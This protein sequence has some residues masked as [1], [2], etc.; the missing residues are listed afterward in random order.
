MN[1]S[2]DGVLIW[3]CADKKY[4]C[5]NGKHITIADRWIHVVLSKIDCQSNYKICIDGQYLSKLSQ[6]DISLIKKE[7][8]LFSNQ[9][10]IF[11]KRFDKNSLGRSIE[12]RIGNFIA[13]KRCLTL[14]EIRAIHQQQTSIKQVKVGT[15]INNKKKH[16]RNVNCHSNSDCFSYK[17]IFLLFLVFFILMICYFLSNI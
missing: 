4:D 6:H 7:P 5:D 10:I 3:L 16:T 11:L 1:W 13:L 2:A 17:L 12:V 9:N 8:N 14:V 15:Y